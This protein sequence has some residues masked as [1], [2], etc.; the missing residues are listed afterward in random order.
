VDTDDT[1]LSPTQHRVLVALKRQGEATADELAD[2]L[3]TS[4]S[5]VRQ[6]LSVLRTAGLISARKERGQRGRPADRYHATIRA[7][8]LVATTDADFSTELLGHLAEEDPEL[9]DRIFDRRRRRLVET[10]ERQLDGKP[11]DEQVGA[12][13]ELLDA[14]GYLADS[15][16]LDRGHFR[17]NLNNCP[18]W[19]V[20]NHFRQACSAELETIR[21]L[22]PD[23][24]VQRITHKTAGAHTCAYDITLGN[25]DAG[26]A[27]AVDVHAAA[28]D[29]GAPTRH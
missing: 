10:T 8:P 16:E 26:P 21:D 7:E 20:A 9:V 23:A 27:D 15:E 14:Q 6:H 22:L 28:P 24:T 4:S 2:I 12:V 11:L 29:V 13:A 19:N 1:E 3:D 5:A 25:S 18:I 17:I